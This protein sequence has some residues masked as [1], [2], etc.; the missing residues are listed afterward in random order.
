MPLCQAFLICCSARAAWVETV[1]WCA[2]Q[3]APGRGSSVTSN[4]P[5]L[6]VPFLQRR[7]MLGLPE[8]DTDPF[9]DTLKDQDSAGNDGRRDEPGDDGAV[10]DSSDSSSDTEYEFEN[11][12]PELLIARQQL[13]AYT[14][15]PGEEEPPGMSA[16]CILLLSTQNAAHCATSICCINQPVVHCVIVDDMGTP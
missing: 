2:S 9:F 6:Y 5:G 3:S 10:G 12:P 8:G 16:L 1:A 13:A 4:V 14:A 7:A 11:E 15:R